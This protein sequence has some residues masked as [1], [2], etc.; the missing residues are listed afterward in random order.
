[1][2]KLKPLVLMMACASGYIIAHAEDQNSTTSNIENKPVTSLETIHVVASADASA[3]GLMEAY[4]GGQVASGGR[5]GIFGNQKNLDTPFN[6]ISYTNQYI[7]ER[8]AKS[9]GD[10]LQADSGVRLAKGFGNFQEAYFIRGFVLNSDDTAYNGLYGILP[11]QYIPTELFERVEVFKGA[12]AFLNGATPGGS[13][14]GGS[15]NLLPKRAGNDP[16]NRVTVGTDFNGGYI[17]NDI[18]RRFGEDQQFGVRVNTA[19]HG[20]GTEID[21]EKNSL[22]LASIALDY[23][24]ENLRLSGDVGYNNNRLES[25]RPSLRLGSAV[26]QLPS[27]KQYTDIHGQSWTYSNE[28][29]VFG[30]FR[31]EYDIND[32]LTAYAAYG[33]RNTT[34]GGVY[35]S[36]IL[37]NV[38]TGD[39]S[40]SASTIPRKD[41][42][43][44][45]E[46][47]LR[48]KFDT[49]VVSHQV[50]L[51]GSAYNQ[52]KKYSYGYRSNIN[53]NLYSP[54]YT[55]SSAINL[56]LPSNNYEKY[57]KAGVTNLRSIALGDNL[58]ILD[59]RLNIMLG[60]RY[61][62]IDQDIYSYGVYKYNNTKNKVTPAVGLSYKL[63]PE[64][65]VYANYIEALVQGD[66]ILNSQTGDYYLPSPFVS[67]QKE[68]GFKYE[69]GKIGGTL[70]YFYTDREKAAVNSSGSQQFSQAKNVHQGIEFN[71]YGQL[72]EQVRILGG[73]S[74]IKTEQ[75]NTYQ[76]LYDGNDV[77]GVPKFQANLGA[78]WQLPIPQNI[79][80]NGRVI[81]TG[82]SYANNSNTFKLKDWTR[83]DLG[84]TYKT[85]VNQTLTA[86]TFGVSN[87]FD[88]DYWASAAVNDYTYLSL[89]EPR[90]FKLSASF[91][92]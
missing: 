17:S 75:K 78:D 64:L 79:S 56:Y 11:R 71:A 82:S 89:G 19:Y 14:V 8:Q 39:A 54:I 21:K 72:N 37:N 45:G 92:F 51:S 1:M 40:L 18:S 59:D 50:V 84:A 61:Q 91:D 52:D 88:K 83:V 53:T 13:G 60:A 76:A 15:I 22:G 74:W 85:L 7:Q 57:A 63:I 62:E 44:T 47:G 42:I 34:E 38:T 24:G 73:A 67:K 49:G 66:G 87:V 27:A 46:V 10:V 5:V 68:L 4:A 77:I 26:N 55:D 32:L 2:I 81:Y 70:D 35:S 12:S 69:N 16:L 36:W 33:F 90:T 29:D 23:K 80:L 9:V 6:L 20:G 43:N 41:Q 31:A 30:S 65:S 28:E 58:T 25:N 86:I 48:A 3:T